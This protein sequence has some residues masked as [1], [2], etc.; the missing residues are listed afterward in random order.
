MNL[1]TRVLLIG[2]VLGAL[3]GVLA[4]YIYFNNAPVKVDETGKE[5]IEPPSAGQSVRV[6]LGLLTVLKM[7]TGE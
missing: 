3:V 1:K 2:G 4:A 7:L 6:G 5:M